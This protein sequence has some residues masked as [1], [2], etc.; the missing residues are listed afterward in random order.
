MRFKPPPPES[1]IGWRVEFRPCEVQLTDF[2]N[3]AY[4]CFIVLLTRV[5]LSYNL[6]FMIPISKVSM[7]VRFKSTLISAVLFGNVKIYLPLCKKVDENMKKAQKRNALLTEKFWFRDN[8]Q[9]KNSK[10]YSLMT[11]NEI[12]N[13]KEVR[14]F[15]C[16]KKN[17][18][19]TNSMIF[20]SKYRTKCNYFMLK[21]KGF[22]GLIPLIQNYLNSMDVDADTQCT[23]Q[24]YLSIISRRA[25]GDVMTAAKWMREFV[26][27]HP[28]YKKDSVI[29]EDINYDLLRRIAGLSESPCS[30]LLGNIDPSRSKT[31]D[32]VP[33][34]LTR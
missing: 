23:L 10:S 14:L 16:L 29:T 8:L 12:I 13:G 26:T 3:A 19:Q 25:K 21:L 15:K 11:V 28:S 18:D 20:V 33:E 34:I 5:I 27:S 7:A 2:E 24:Q 4:V 17:T 32:D 6:H 9:D 31:Q 1:S 22:P 30:K